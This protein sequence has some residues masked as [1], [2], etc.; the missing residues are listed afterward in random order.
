MAIS[1]RGSDQFPV[2]FP[3]GLREKIKREA[4]ENGRSMNSEIIARLSGDGETLR[5][6]FAMAALT[7]IVSGICSSVNI[8]DRA[9]DR[10]AFDHA[11]KDAYSLADAMFKAR[12]ENA[13]A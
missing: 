2:R 13:N 3:D 5:D 1:S 4:E 10:V 12:K 9:H 6:K 7:G 11:A 8:G